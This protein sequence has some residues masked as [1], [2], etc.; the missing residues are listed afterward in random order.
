MMRAALF[1]LPLA[2][3]ATSLPATLVTAAVQDSEGGKILEEIL[4]VPRIEEANPD[5][6]R[7]LWHPWHQNTAAIAVTQRHGFD[8]LEVSQT[9]G[10]GTYTVG[11]LRS[12][13]RAP[14][15][16]L[17]FTHI[18]DSF[19]RLAGVKQQVDPSGVS[20]VID[21]ETGDKLI[22]VCIH[23]SS[24]TIESRVAETARSIF[25][26]CQDDYDDVFEIARPLVKLA[27]AKFPEQMKRIDPDYLRAQLEAEEGGAE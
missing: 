4:K 20:E 11:E 3:C 13:K 12:V 19:A 8:I 7:I 10:Y 2:A 23:G 15:G 18:A 25:R 14:I 16:R 26:H 5:T 27:W 21:P 24:F 17:E 9:D 22:R 6:Y 1:A